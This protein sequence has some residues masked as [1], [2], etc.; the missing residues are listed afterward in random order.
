MRTLLIAFIGISSFIFAAEEEIAALDFKQFPLSF[1]QQNLEQPT[2]IKPKKSPALAATLSS[3]APGLGHFYLGDNKTAGALLGTYGLEFGVA[4]GAKNQNVIHSDLIVLQNTSFYG[5]YAAY[6]DA[7]L[8]RDNAGYRYEMPKET[9]KELAQAPFS[10]SVLKK[11]EVWGGYL[12][13]LAIATT[14]GHFMSSQISYPL[15]TSGI[16]P[17]LAFPIGIGEEA[18]FRGFVQSALSEPLTPWGGIAA[19]SILFGAVHIPNAY[20]FNAHQRRQYYTYGIP[21]I[22]TLGAYFG[23]LTHKNHSL[24]ESVA[25]HAWYDFTVFMLGALA[26]KASYK[27]PVTFGMSFRF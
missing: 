13:A 25:I 10:F 5:V 3:L 14:L 9:L 26:S 7:R 12:G 21:L 20:S 15:S 6:R 11:P 27:T 2:F 16:F 8:M 24:K 18:Y 22:T 4:F 19:T 23:Y 17:P 1:E